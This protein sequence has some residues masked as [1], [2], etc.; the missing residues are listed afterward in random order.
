[1]AVMTAQGLADNK[2]V[3]RRL[4]E[5]DADARKASRDINA[6][7]SSS[8]AKDFPASC[9]SIYQAD[10]ARF[11]AAEHDFNTEWNRVVTGLA[12]DS[13]QL[14]ATYSRFVDALCMLEEQNDQ[15]AAVRDSK[16]VEFA[17]QFVGLMHLLKKS[18]LSIRFQAIEQ[19]LQDLRKRLERALDEVTEAKIQRGLNLV[20]NAITFAINPATATRRVLMACGTIAVSAII[21]ESLGP[22]GASV[23][24]TKHDTI[25]EIADANKKLKP[26]IRHLANSVP[27]IY[28]LK[29]DSDEITKALGRVEKVRKRIKD[30]NKEFAD[31]A[32][33]MEYHAREL[34]SVGKAL[35]A[36]MRSVQSA[37]SR[38]SRNSREY[39]ELAREF[40]EWEKWRHSPDDG[41]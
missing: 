5:L 22:R 12:T 34:N 1:M 29:M 33:A 20:L 2:F 24:A 37:K 23:T 11:D 18:A 40:A 7:L 27:I 14:I 36:A 9:I 15:F 35:D 3:R 41:E 21:D 8:L 6:N 39:D 17:T 32:R 30:A 28:E 31:A 16:L 26:A 19:E 38:T 4:K 25:G 13:K 10:L